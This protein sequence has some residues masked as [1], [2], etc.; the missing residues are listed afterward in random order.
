MPAKLHGRDGVIILLLAVLAFLGNYYPVPLMFGVDILLGL[1]F[2]YLL[3]LHYGLVVALLASLPA[4]VA[5]WLIWDHGYSALLLFAELVVLAWLMRRFP[6]AEPPLL[7]AF[8][9]VPWGAGAS[10]LLYHFA[11]ELPVLDAGLVALKQAINSITAITVAMVLHLVV[12]PRWLHRRPVDVTT[13]E[14]LFYVPATLVILVMTALLFLISQLQLRAVEASFAERLTLTRTNLQDSTDRLLNQLAMDLNRI[15]SRCF[16]HNHTPVSSASC[17][18]TLLPFT[19]WENVY[20]QTPDD[21]Q[22]WQFTTA[23]GVPELDPRGGQYMSEVPL[24]NSSEEAQFAVTEDGMLLLFMRRSMASEVWLGASVKLADNAA[25]FWPS[26]PQPMQRQSWQLNGAT[27]VASGPT[28]SELIYPD[29]FVTRTVTAGMDQRTIP[30]AQALLEQPNMNPINRWAGSIYYLETALDGLGLPGSLR[31]EISPRAEQEAMYRLYA[32]LLALALLFILLTLMTV[33]W[34]AQWLLRPMQD[35]VNTARRI[36][37]Q[38]TTD[39]VQWQWPTRRTV[40]EVTELTHSLQGMGQLLYEQY[41]R[42]A[43]SRLE[44]EQQVKSRTQDLYE[45]QQH[46]NSIMQSMDGALW[47]GTAENDRLQ[48]NLVSPGIYRLTGFTPEEWM[49]DTPAMLERILGGGRSRVASAMQ[50][51]RRGGNGELEFRFRHAKGG[52]RALRVRFWLVYDERG[53][54]KR[55]DGLATDISDWHAAQAKIKAQDELLSQQARRA[56]MGDMVSN[57][58]HQWRQ[59]LNSLRLV[60]ANLLDAQEFGELP[61]EVLTRSLHQCDDLIDGMNQTVR[62]F[63]TFFR[64]QKE[65]SVFDLT[66]VVRSALKVMDNTF[67]DYPVALTSDLAPAV[68]VKGF[69]NE[70]LQALLVIMQNAQEVLGE[71]QVLAGSI[72]VTLTVRDHQAIVAITDNAGGVAADIEDKI[73]D[74]YFTTRPE[75][76]GIGLYMA[77][78]LIEGQMQGEIRLQNRS[79]GA[80]FEIVLF[81]ASADPQA[82]Q[83]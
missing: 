61:P 27:L 82:P 42:D 10:Y 70:V 39:P 25:R 64:P 66:A 40:R 20:F 7:V 9:W 29:Q 28:L 15:D 73:F 24:N 31:V 72:H 16:A 6:K 13:S 59:P 8:I 35:L 38:I 21:A 4:L 12:A 11:L 81:T 75:G 44:L 45:V 50:A 80:T 46:V 2:I 63:L 1:I 78:T 79:Q 52:E 68:Q 54:P 55:I 56:A 30:I 22:W 48:L 34:S 26:S 62:D 32:I 51:V 43:D 60:H 57:I 18:E 19:A 3:L 67:I 76:T 33:R 5:T 53:R 65:A 17:L 58:A 69:A 83:S 36:P 49:A 74:P 37:Q 41:K 23:S 47:S 14:L 71:R 77:R